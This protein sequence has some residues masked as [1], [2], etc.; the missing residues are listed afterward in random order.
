MYTTFW[1]TGINITSINTTSLVISSS[2]NHTP[3][4]MPSCGSKAA[5][6]KFKGRHEDV[7]KF[8]KNVQG[9]LSGELP[10]TSILSYPCSLLYSLFHLSLFSIPTPSIFTGSISIDCDHYGDVV[11]SQPQNLWV[12]Q[13]EIIL[14]IGPPYFPL[15]LC[16]GNYQEP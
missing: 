14:S 4:M 8:W 12:L 15:Q 6:V 5:L 1:F 10:R 2:M 3:D 7:K 13:A 11:D 16:K 9:I